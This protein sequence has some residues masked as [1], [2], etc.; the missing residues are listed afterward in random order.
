MA[1]CNFKKVGV[2]FYVLWYKNSYTCHYLA[3]CPLQISFHLSCFLCVFSSHHMAG[4]SHHR[5]E[6]PSEHRP[7]LAP[8]TYSDPNWKQCS[9]RGPAFHGVTTSRMRRP[10]ISHLR[11]RGGRLVR[12]YHEKDYCVDFLSHVA[13]KLYGS[14]IGYQTS[15]LEK[16]FRG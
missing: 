10:K 14:P 6:S 7:H 2:E 16:G 8:Q 5:L 15:T 12:S 9:E 11:R 4:I 3:K 1:G 13:L